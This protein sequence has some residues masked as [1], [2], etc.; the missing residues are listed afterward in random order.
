MTGRARWIA[1]WTVMALLTAACSGTS[2]ANHDTATTVGAQATTT[3]AAA[4]QALEQPSSRCG[5]PDIS[6]TLVRF[7]AADGPRVSGRPVRVLAVRR[8]PGQ[9]GSARLRHRPA[10]L[11][12]VGLP[13][14]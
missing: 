1:A 4:Q 7:E 2:G 5:P 14:R 12:P 9:A 3:T 11:R 8:L 10:L 6:A 13:S